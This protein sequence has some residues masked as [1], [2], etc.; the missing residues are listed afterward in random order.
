MT[1]QDVMQKMSQAK[2]SETIYAD[3][4]MY[5]IYYFRTDF[6]KGELVLTPLA[7]KDNVLVGWGDHYVQQLKSQK[8]TESPR[9]DNDETM[10]NMGTGWV[11]RGGLIVTNYHV[12]KNSK[13][14]EVYFQDG[15]R[16]S[17]EVVSRDT[18]NDLAILKT[19]KKMNMRALPMA[20]EWTDIGTKV[21]TIGY[22]HPDVMG[23]S[24]KLTD[25]VVSSTSGVMD[26]PRFY[27]ITVP[28][29]SGNS[30]GP[31]LNMSGEVVG[32]VTSKLSAINMLK[33]TGDLPEN[34]NYAVKVQYLNIL[35]KTN[36][37]M[38]SIKKSV[39][40]ET[41]EDLAAKLKNSVCIVLAK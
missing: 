2:S 15:F 28:V 27:Q 39:K 36:D 10:L 24:P 7:F 22:P 5:E 16:S 40:N 31:L 21:F 35:L 18:A 32:I 25:G 23:I 14:I 33:Y 17:A 26:D 30:G 12:I 11:C 6:R 38:H 34:V 9:K 41:L 13:K 19:A 29:Q 20:T 1:K 3:N 37:D 8:R 4:D